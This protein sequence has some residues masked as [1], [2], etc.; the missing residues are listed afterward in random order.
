MPSKREMI[1]PALVR[2]GASALIRRAMPWDGVITLNYHRIGDASPS[3]FDRGLWSATADMFDRQVKFAKSHFDIIRPADLPHLC[4]RGKGRHLIITFDDGYLDNFEVAFPILKNNHASAVFFI[5][6]GFIDNPRLP[7][8]DEIAWMVRTANKTQIDLNPWIPLPLT[9]DEPGREKAVRTLLRA[10]KAM[11]SAD[12]ARYLDAVAA[13]TGTGRCTAAETKNLWMNWNMLR[14]MRAAGMTIGGHTVNHPILG[15]MT[16]EG[17]WNEISGCGK[18]IAQE[19]GQPMTAFSYPVGHKNA[20]DSATRDCLKR[21]GV[22]YAFSYYGG[23]ARFDRWDDYDIRRLPIDNDL[24]FDHFRVIVELPQ[25]F[26]RE[27]TPV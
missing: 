11:P 7:W 1:A 27:E 26:G 6:T 9:F 20:F 16:P 8:W 3:N 2:T 12:T 22:Q 24:S 23:I 14:D 4:K 19:L 15:R 17:Q 5:T 18:R 21:S 25:L 13:A 10:Y